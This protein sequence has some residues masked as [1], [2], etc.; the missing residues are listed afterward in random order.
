MMVH[1]I[2][3]GLAGLSAAVRLSDRGQSVVVHEAAAHGGGRCRSFYDETL[4]RRIDNGNHML[5]S[6]NMYAMAYLRAIG[7]LD[8]LYQPEQAAFPFLDLENGARWQI[9]PGFNALPGASLLDYLSILKLAWASENATIADVFDTTRPLFRNFWQPLCVSV[10]NTPVE[11]AAARLMWP[12]VKQTFGRGAAACRP[13]IA[14]LG[15]S[16]SFIDP[17]LAV[18]EKRGVRVHF[19]QR[20]RAINFAEKQA[21]ALSFADDAEVALGA[22]DT[23]IL[24]VPAE[25]AATLVPDLNPPDKFRSIVNGHFLLPEHGED[26]NFLGMVGGVS[27]WLF[28]RGDVASVTISAAD[29]LVAKSAGDI[30]KILWAEVCTALQLGDAPVGRHRIIKEKRA[31][32]EQSPEQVRLRPATRT[33]WSNL[34]LAGDWTQSGLPATIEGAVRSGHLAADCVV[35]S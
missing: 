33:R 8:T 34:L 22:D 14:K 2:G 31:T 21:G 7:G 28:V 3:A 23:L 25:A 4:E 11:V 26:N 24:A 12:V 16:E 35:R 6:G 13:G 1:I 10:L 30:A 15:L 17:A 29:D 9:R 18:L 19:N 5:L 32:I 27:Q 20:L